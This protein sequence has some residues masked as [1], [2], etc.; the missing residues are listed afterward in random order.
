MPQCAQGTLYI[1]L[2]YCHSFLSETAVPRIWMRKQYNNVTH[3]SKA[4]N[5]YQNKWF[6]MLKERPP[7]GGLNR[8]YVPCPPYYKDFQA[9]L[10]PK[11]CAVIPTDF[12]DLTSWGYGWSFDTPI[13][14]LAVIDHSL[15]KPAWQTLSGG[16]Y[17][18]TRL[19]LLPHNQP[20]RA[21]R[22]AVRA[23][24]LDQWDASV[25]GC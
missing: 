15:R 18:N 22:R 3:T 21:H 19:F 14:W 10:T 25:A 12:T 4:V 8:V 11:I 6:V 5:P 13:V 17:P 2:R 1:Y 9:V 16:K 24:W 20:M 23:R 7:S